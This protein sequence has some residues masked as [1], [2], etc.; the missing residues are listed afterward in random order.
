VPSDLVFCGT[1]TDPSRQAGFEVTPARPVMGMTGPTGSA[2][3][4]AF[5]R[6]AG[7]GAL[8]M[9][10]QTAAVNPSYLALDRSGRF[11]LAANE[12]RDFDGGASGAITSFAIDYDTG[13]LRRLSQ[14]RSEGGNPCHL[15]MSRD[16]RFLLVANHEAGNVA[17]LPLAESGELSAAVDIRTD[18]AVDHRQP[19]AHFITPDRSGSFVLTA[20][21]GTD[22][23]MV[24][25]QSTETGRLTPNDPAWG[26]THKGGSPRHLAFSPSGRYLFANGE[27]DLSLSLFR[28]DPLRGALD[29]IQHLRTVPDGIDTNGHSTAQMVIHPNGRHVYVANRGTDS[30]AMF[31]FDEA[32][33]RIAF[34]GIVS[35][36]GRTP[37]YFD[38]APGGDRLYVANQNSDSIECFAIDADSGGLSHAGH[39]AAL[40]APTCILFATT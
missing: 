2:G 22:R 26:Q 20:D 16:G 35:T 32:S 40:P 36:E 38:V 5:R 28:Y 14:V 11:L 8:T 13:A 12:V 18:E 23:V 10:S 25:R 39:A 4:Y 27:A 33:E 1:Y 9:L 19:H 31:D 30:I 37:R 17:V 3:I 21:T 7:T 34:R 24:Y 6:D 29:P 15:S